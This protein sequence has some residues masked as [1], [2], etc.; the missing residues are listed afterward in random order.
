MACLR[1]L[2]L[3][4]IVGLLS[5]A[6]LLAPTGVLGWSVVTDWVGGGGESGASLAQATGRSG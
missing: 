3:L 4:L 1:G 2:K 5:T 6:L